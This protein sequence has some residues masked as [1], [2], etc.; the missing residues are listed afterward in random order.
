V[1]VGKLKKSHLLHLGWLVLV[2]F[3]HAGLGNYAKREVYFSCD[4]LS[5]KVW[6][7]LWETVWSV[8]NRNNSQTA[9]YHQICLLAQ[10]RAAPR[11]D[12][13]PFETAMAYVIEAKDEKRHLECLPLR[14]ALASSDS[15][16]T[17]TT[18]NQAGGGCAA[19]VVEID[20]AR[21]EELETLRGFLN[22]VITEG[23][24]SPPLL[25]FLFASFLVVLLWFFSSSD[26]LRVNTHV[27]V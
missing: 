26:A 10:P 21:E 6:E 14:F 27:Q 2:A 18:D 11:R 17:S 23:A 3:R 24:C 25:L 1:P 8:T 5:R 16:Q 19:G 4:F 7:G 22:H 15:N 9:P 12:T 13:Q 20:R